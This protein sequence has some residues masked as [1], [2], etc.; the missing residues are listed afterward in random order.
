MGPYS[1]GDISVPMANLVSGP[2][3][4]AFLKSLTTKM[5]NSIHGSRTSLFKKNGMLF[6]LTFS[7]LYNDAV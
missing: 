2:Y 5:A 4:F 3:P 6:V 1:Q 7:F